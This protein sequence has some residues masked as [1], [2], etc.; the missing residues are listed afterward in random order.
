MSPAAA[1]LLAEQRDSA[2]SVK[3]FVPDLVTVLARADLSISQAGY[4]TV[5]DVLVGGCRSVLVPYARDGETEQG[6]RAALLSAR[7][8]AVSVAEEDLTPERLAAAADRAMA[9]PPA[10]HGLDLDGAETTARILRKHLQ[11]RV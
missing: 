5:A 11:P 2:L 3:T 8:L 4:N 10:A 7:G 9:L 6:D 1:A